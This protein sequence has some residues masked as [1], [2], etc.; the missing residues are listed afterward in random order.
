MIAAALALA[1]A[2]GA[3]ADA[4][5]FD[6]AGEHRQ[7]GVMIC[8]TEPG[9]ALTID[10]VE[11]Q[12]DEAG[13]VIFGHDRDAGETATIRLSLDGETVR[14]ETVE[15]AAR[16][17]DIQRVDGVPQETVDPPPE[18]LERIRAEGVLKRAAHASRWNGNGFSDGFA[19]PA[20]GRVSGVFGS[21]RVYNGQPGTPH[22][23][24]D[25]AAPTGTPAYAPADGL[26][27]LAHD[28]MFYEGGIVFID[29]GQ[30]FNSA[31]FHFDE[32]LVEEGERVEKGQEI[33]RIGAGGR[34]TGPHVDWRIRWHG[35][36]VDPQALVEITPPAGD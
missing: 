12:A 6:C 19:L 21:Q 8:R 26:V 31:L 34:A 7:G 16:E 9:A 18:V 30:G 11:T 22:Y 1:A 33:A 25:I 14:E 28:D 2:Q 35:R 13:W 27:T 15:V 20:E 5:R 23:G 10:D 29:H 17:Y 3:G 4:I 24:L 36:N 32:V